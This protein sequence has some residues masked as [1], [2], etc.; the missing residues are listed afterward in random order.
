MNIDS[1]SIISG[2]EYR[3]A[4]RLMNGDEQMYADALREV[5]SGIAHKV[6][7]L[8]SSLRLGELGFFL[9]ELNSLRGELAMVG[10]MELSADADL[11]FNAAKNNSLIG[12]RSLFSHMRDR[13]LAFS[14]N[15]L[16]ILKRENA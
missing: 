2:L 12:T 6:D 7:M 3:T 1:L 10:A 15:V 14:L 9:V 13:L 8:D 5:A 4:I 16:D 11:V